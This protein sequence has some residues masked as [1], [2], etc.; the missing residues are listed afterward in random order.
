MSYFLP[1]YAD[2]AS[3]AIEAPPA[4]CAAPPS[5][6]AFGLSL[7]QTDLSSLLEPGAMVRNPGVGWAF[8]NR[9]RQLFYPPWLAG[10]WQVGGG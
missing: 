10:T 7:G 4:Q 9:Q 5:Q 8:N 1:T 2:G 6:Q 3:G